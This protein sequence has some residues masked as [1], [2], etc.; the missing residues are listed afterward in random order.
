MKFDRVD[1]TSLSVLT[2]LLP[3]GGRGEEATPLSSP[4]HP[5]PRLTRATNRNP[6][7]FHWRNVREAG[8]LIGHLSGGGAN[9]TRFE[10][11]W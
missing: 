1:Y 8:I 4:P 11:K 10:V 7:S 5:H 6:A 2:A 3:K 9:A